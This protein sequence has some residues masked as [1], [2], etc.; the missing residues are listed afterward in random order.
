MPTGV[1]NGMVTS[2]GE[3]IGIGDRVATRRNHRDLDVANRD[4]WTVTALA[5]DGSLHVTGSRG[6]R[7][8]PPTYVHTHVE[9]AYATTV[10]GAQGETVDH[11]H[12]LLGE[13][14]G[15]AAAY[16]AMTR[17]RLRNTA[18]FVADSPA[19][20]RRQWVEVFGRDRADLG[21]GHAA[22]IAAEDIE[23][24]GPTADGSAGTLQAAALREELNRPRTRPHQPYP[25]GPA[26]SSPRI[27]R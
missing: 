20:A 2:A 23:R 14:T 12:L 6:E 5:E 19:D 1:V 25:T 13:H 24:Y 4:T 8:L 7:L 21:P 16:V 17:G 22:Q 10:Y 26:R 18:H 3:Q 9:L 27:G 11:A 15:A